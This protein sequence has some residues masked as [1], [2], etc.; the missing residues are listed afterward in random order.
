MI[1]DIA[2]ESVFFRP[3]GPGGPELLGNIN[4]NV[5]SEFI[6]VI[7]GPAGSGKSILLDILSLRC[8][9]SSGDIFVN[10]INTAKIPSRRLRKF[11]RMTNLIPERPDFL[12]EKSIFDNMS[13][14]LRLEGIP[15]SMFFDRIME[16]L[17]PSGLIPKKDQPPSSLSE[18]ERK[19]LSLSMAMVRDPCLLICDFNLSGSSDEQILVDMIFSAREKGIGAVLSART[20]FC[21]VFEQEQLVK[22]K[23]GSIV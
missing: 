14:I 5:S 6:T 17:G 18:I 21:G 16:S 8:R 10:G 1:L 15:G 13:Y 22:M 9:P 2:L 19:I 11:Q 23:S 3:S 4:L 20:G 12:E 7:A